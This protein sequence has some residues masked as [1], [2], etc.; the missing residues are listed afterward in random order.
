MNA[1]LGLKEMKKWSKT[2]SQ[3]HTVV[4]SI[5][6]D[7]TGATESNPKRLLLGTSTSRCYSATLLSDSGDSS[8]DSE[9]KIDYLG[10]LNSSDSSPASISEIHYVQG[11][12]GTR[13]IAATCGR[14]LRTRLHCLFS[15]EGNDQVKEAF[16]KSKETGQK[17]VELP[18][19]VVKTDVKVLGGDFCMLSEFGVYHGT[20]EEDKDGVKDAGILMYDDLG[21]V[22][23]VPCGVGLTKFNFVL[24]CNDGNVVVISRVSLEVVQRVRVNELACVGREKIKSELIT[25]ARRVGAVWLRRG[26]DIFHVS[27]PFEERDVWKLRLRKILRG[28]MSMTGKGVNQEKADEAEFDE[29]QALCSTQEERALV[30]LCRAE[31]HLEKGR[32]ELAARWLARAPKSL[33]GFAS[34]SLRLC[35]PSLLSPIDVTST[36]TPSTSSLT[37]YLTESFSKLSKEKNKGI[38]LAMLGAWITELMLSERGALS[39]T[40]NKHMDASIGAF[41]ARNAKQLDSK[42]TLSIMKSHSAAAHEIAA[43]AAACGD[44]G[45]AV[46]AALSIKSGNVDETA[47]QRRGAMAALKMLDGAEISIAKDVYYFHAEEIL[48]RAPVEASDAWIRRY[49]DGL[50]PEMLLPAI[51]FVGKRAAEAREQQ[52]D[53]TDTIEDLQEVGIL[54]YLEGVVKLGNNSAA[55]HNHLMTLYADLEDETPLFRYL[56]NT[57]TTT[58]SPTLPLNLK[59]TLN[60]ILKTQR[61]HRS[62]VKVY[63]AMGKREAA[64]ELAL[65]VDP[66]LARELA[67]NS[68]GPEQKKLWLMIAKDAAKEHTSNHTQTSNNTNTNA[69]SKDAVAKVIA[70]LKES[71]VLSI[72]DVLPFLPDFVQIDTFKEEIVAALSV[73][74]EK[75][76]RYKDEVN[77]CDMTCDSLRE[78]IEEVQSAPIQCPRNAKCALSGKPLLRDGKSLC[79]EGDNFYVFPSGFIVQKKALRTTV[80]LTLSQIQQERVVEIENELEQLGGDTYT[81]E[82]VVATASTFGAAKQKKTVIIDKSAAERERELEKIKT[83]QD[84]YDGLIASECP[85]TG[86]LMVDSINQPLEGWDDDLN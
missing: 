66:T 45:S 25:D 36:S 16:T 11:H 19:S 8:S 42:T 79:D 13:I 38:Q 41:L 50:D 3:D 68:I 27:S 85:L 33:A 58:T 77:E 44:Y 64:V 40:N 18:G 80:F 12:K 34:T 55:V 75:I 6:W 51:L 60:V 67:E 43:F 54:S 35:L 59:F 81:E 61:H 73:Y 49:S 56:T 4:T 14:G 26:R 31:F 72:E 57:T 23:G 53:E 84:E 65:N 78:E 71:G 28:G 21:A 37:S 76:Q 9:P 86:K 83:L 1:S 5:A 74:S 47:T 32:G 52:D 63:M 22:G 82:I 10:T 39:T 2:L 20:I 15:G 70:V 29:V 46:K 69:V 24:L 30:N 17:F 7:V 48:S 62:A